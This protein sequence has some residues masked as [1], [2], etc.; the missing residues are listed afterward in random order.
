MGETPQERRIAELEAR[1]VRL[2]A[3]LRWAVEYM[4]DGIPGVAPHHECQFYSDPEK[5]ACDFH[6]AWA[7]A[8][9]LV[10]PRAIPSEG[11]RP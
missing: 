7:E 10:A 8:M 4:E 9:S 1:N 2:A 3:S 6:D 11:E 5:G